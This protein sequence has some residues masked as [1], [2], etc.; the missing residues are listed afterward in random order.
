MNSPV[1]KKSINAHPR[2]TQKTKLCFY[3]G[4]YL[5]HFNFRRIDIFILSIKLSHSKILCIC[6]KTCFILSL[7]FR[8]TNLSDLCSSDCG[9]YR[10]SMEGLSNFFLLF[11]IFT[12]TYPPSPR[13]A[14]LDICPKTFVYWEKLMKLRV[15]FF[16]FFFFSSSS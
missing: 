7:D 15:A 9:H 14:H 5:I 6:L 11:F 4:L 12:H 1:P 16:V 8:Y 3:L 10:W 2:H 13:G